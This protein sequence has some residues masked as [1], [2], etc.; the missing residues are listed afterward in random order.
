MRSE[1]RST[2]LRGLYAITPERSDTDALV[3]SVEECLAG[4]AALVQYRAKHA[5]PELA[6]AQAR[7]LASAC[8]AARVPLV[9]NDSIELALAA[10]AD[11][12][13]LGRED[14]AASEAR[15]AFP[16]GI[17]GVPCY[18]EPERAHA[19][20]EAGADY[21]AVGSVFPSATKP[22]ARRAALETIAAAKRI[23][24]LPV[25]AIGGITLDNAAR[26]VAAGAQ[27]LAVI[28]AVFDAPDVRAASQSF[29]NHYAEPRNA[30]AQPRPV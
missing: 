1:A 16:Q 18:D 17:I 14:A 30:R 12:V 13:H 28:T 24:G 22:G 5:S 6:L 15:A 3:R 9:I 25:A 8:R 7:R 10:G 23:S 26:V 2:L 11:G 4:G 27:M 20:R 29:A 21:V 19:A